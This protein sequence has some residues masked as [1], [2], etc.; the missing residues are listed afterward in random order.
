MDPDSDVD[1]GSDV[2]TDVNSTLSLSTVGGTDAGSCLCGCGGDPCVPQRRYAIAGHTSFTGETILFR[3]NG[4]CGIPL[5]DALA[6]NFTA[7]EGRDDFVLPG[8]VGSSLSVR[9]GVS[10]CFP[11]TST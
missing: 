5:R 7:L 4:E 3:V 9:L 2:T 6:R 10:I 1:M 11:V 8:E